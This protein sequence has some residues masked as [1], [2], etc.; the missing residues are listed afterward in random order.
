[1]KIVY[2]IIIPLLLILIMVTAYLQLEY[3][4]PPYDPELENKTQHLVNGMSWEKNMHSPENIKK[5]TL[6]LPSVWE[7]NIFDPA[8]GSS[9]ADVSV[10]SA[11][12]GG[13]ELLGIYSYGKTKGAIISV[14]QSNQ[15]GSQ[16]NQER[17]YQYNQGKK[18]GAN[19]T[20]QALK[21]PKMY[22]EIGEK[23]PNNFILK[24][25]GDNYAIVAGG[26]EA[27]KLTIKYGTKSSMQRVDLANKNNV[28]Q[29]I[30]VIQRAKQIKGRK[31]EVNVK[32]EPVAKPANNNTINS[33]RK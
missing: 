12:A 15:P 18:Y 20:I 33:I 25:V 3:Q 17:R 21:K 19:R 16:Y 1:M 2:A 11:K 29:Q 26:G 10:S 27:L 28:K 22:F 6:L 14:R 7:K 31:K 8:R 9:V 4:P 13:M 24:S 5:S 30:S 23:L 32:V